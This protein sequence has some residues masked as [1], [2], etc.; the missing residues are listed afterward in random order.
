MDT[1][2]AE[3]SKAPLALPEIVQADVRVRL[4][5]FPHM[6]AHVM[7]RARNRAIQARQAQRMP[8]GGRSTAA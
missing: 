6:Q 3:V 8:G 1:R 4:R 7:H 2:Y 5:G